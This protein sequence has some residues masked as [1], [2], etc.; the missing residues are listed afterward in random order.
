MENALEL[1]LR[2]A[3]WFRNVVKKFLLELVVSL[4]NFGMGGSAAR[5]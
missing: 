1:W 2:V 4:M 3:G 5:A